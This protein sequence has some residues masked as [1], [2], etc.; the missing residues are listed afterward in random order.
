MQTKSYHRRAALARVIQA[1]CTIAALTLF[2]LG[3]AFGLFGEYHTA[4][5]WLFGAALLAALASI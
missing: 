3:F 5:N 2:G 4:S 1:A